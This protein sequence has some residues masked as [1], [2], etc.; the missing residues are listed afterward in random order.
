M[1]SSAREW[2][3]VDGKFI[4][5]NMGVTASCHHKT[6]GACGGCYFRLIEALSQIEAESADAGHA[7]AVEVLTQLKSEDGQ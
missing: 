1:G 7:L 5:D 4:R 6:R 2:K 3:V